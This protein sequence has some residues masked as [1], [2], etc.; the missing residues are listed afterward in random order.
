MLTASYPEAQS[1]PSSAKKQL[2]YRTL[3]DDDFASLLARIDQSLQETTLQ[4]NEEQ[5]TTRQERTGSSKEFPYRNALPTLEPSSSSYKMRNTAPTSHFSLGHLTDLVQDAV[6]TKGDQDDVGDYQYL[7]KSMSQLSSASSSGIDSKDRMMD[8]RRDMVSPGASDDDGE[9]ARNRKVTFNENVM[10]KTISFRSGF[11]S[12]SYRTDDD[13]KLSEIFGENGPDLETLEL[14]SDSGHDGA[15]N[16]PN[17]TLDHSRVK[18]GQRAEPYILGTDAF[19]PSTTS[20]RRAL[21]PEVSTM[22]DNKKNGS[23]VKKEGLS[24]SVEPITHKMITGVPIQGISKAPRVARAAEPPSLPKVPAVSRPARSRGT[25]VTRAPNHSTPKALST[26]KLTASSKRQ[27]HSIFTPSPA[28]SK[29]K[30]TTSTPQT[31]KISTFVTDPFDLPSKHTPFKLHSPFSGTPFQEFHSAREEQDGQDDTFEALEGPGPLAMLTGMDYEAGD[32][33]D[34]VHDEFMA[35]K[36]DMDAILKSD[37]LGDGRSILDEDFRPA[38]EMSFLDDNK[39]D[40]D[41]SVSSFHDDQSILGEDDLLPLPKTFDE[42]NVYAAK[43]PKSEPRHTSKLSN[44]EAVPL[45]LPSPGTFFASLSGKL[46]SLEGQTDIQNRPSF[47]PTAARYVQ[48]V[49]E[50]VH[51]TPSVGTLVTPKGSR[52]VR[53]PLYQSPTEPASQHQS[54][55]VFETHEIQRQPVP[56]SRS[57]KLPPPDLF[58]AMTIPNR[59]LPDVVPGRLNNPTTRN[60]VLILPGKL[61][62][63]PSTIKP[64]QTAP[65]RMPQHTTYVGFP[66]TSYRS[67]GRV[68][69][70]IQNPTIKPAYWEVSSIGKPHCESTIASGRTTD[71]NNNRYGTAGTRK[72]A[73]DQDVFVFAYASGRVEAMQRAEVMLSFHPLMAGQYSQTFHLRCNGRLVVIELE[74]TATV[75]VFRQPQQQQQR[76]QQQQQHQNQQ[77]PNLKASIGSKSTSTGWTPSLAS[78]VN[79]SSNVEALSVTYGGNPC[80]QLAFNDVAVGRTKVIAI[81]LCNNSTSITRAMTVDITAPTS[82]YVSTGRMKIT[83]R[84]PVWSEITFRPHRAGECEGEVIIRAAGGS[85]WRTKVSGRGI[86]VGSTPG[87][88]GAGEG[89]G[90]VVPL[91]MAQRATVLTKG[92]SADRKPQ[93]SGRDA[94]LLKPVMY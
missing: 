68:T 63:A 54:P 31:P 81:C 11:D 7:Y 34:D 83:P 19:L 46:G 39:S 70:S 26:P 10:E 44:L 85:V 50:T 52:R 48:R 82:F 75:P 32:V 8:F 47:T 67:I 79:M 4:D 13:A 78:S 35:L 5:H 55:T 65:P 24:K 89:R 18:T 93:S 61:G 62:G 28:S 15:L 30:M 66:P 71:R 86:V 36:A 45:S 87:F 56:V 57:D 21:I 80:K 76:Y 38:S 1:P 58:D 74:G 16:I 69:L 64:W 84:I 29:P 17:R 51:A 90:D 42:E 12:F 22:L 25:P 27:P 94:W 72:H 6:K 2:G 53:A 14:S 91:W 43:T 37:I 88:G 73:I 3:V 60:P 20:S 92:P 33:H 9:V 41:L 23:S 49:A 59:V 77:L 40:G